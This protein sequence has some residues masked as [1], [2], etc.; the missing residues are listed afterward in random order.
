MKTRLSWVLATAVLA[1]TG[2]A[3]IYLVLVGMAWLYLQPFV[4]ALEVMALAA[5]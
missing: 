2:L 5:S 3:M 4:G 1:V